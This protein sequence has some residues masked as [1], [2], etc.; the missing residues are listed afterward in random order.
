MVRAFARMAHLSRDD[1]AAKMGHPVCR[2][3]GFGGFGQ[4]FGRFADRSIIAP[5]EIGKTL[6]RT[7]PFNVEMLNIPFEQQR[8][9]L[10]YICDRL[11]RFIGGKMDAS[12]NGAYLAEVAAQRYGALVRRWAPEARLVYSVADLHHLRAARRF[13]VEAGLA[14]DAPEGAEQAAGLRA[15]ELMAV[16]GA[17]AVITHSSFEASLLKRDA[18][19][20][21]I[22]LVPWDVPVTPAAPLGGRRGVAFV[23]SYGHAPNLD[24]AHVLLEKVMPL[25]WAEAPDIPLLLAGSDLPATLREAAAPFPAA[26]VLGWVAALDEVFAQVRLTAAP[27]RYG[28]GLK[29]KVLDSLAA[30]IPCLCSPMAAEGMDLPPGLAAL[31]TPSSEAMAAAILQLHRD[32]AGCAHLA[33]AAQAWVGEALST[34]RIDALMAGAVG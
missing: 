16:L 5:I 10:F 22:R 23:G 15:A 11:P 28:A 12:G 31:V 30:G 3:L 17:D 1:A 7:V 2:P 6:K 25:V 4:D 26:K 9:V 21:D 19:E 27:L 29:G 13:A 14:P 8:Q 18:P 24:A 20:A 33:M 32:D 34:M